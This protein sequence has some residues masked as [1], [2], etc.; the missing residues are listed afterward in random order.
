MSDIQQ[1]IHNF[2]SADNIGV[3]KEA[4]EKIS[5]KIKS[6]VRITVCLY[7]YRKRNSC[8]RS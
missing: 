1:F 7:L 3:T 8:S 5:P 4:I 2:K 6:N